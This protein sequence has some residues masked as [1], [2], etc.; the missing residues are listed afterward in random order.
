MIEVEQ[1]LLK[2]GGDVSPQLVEKLTAIR[3]V[4]FWYIR[5]GQT[6]WNLENR[7]MGSTDISLNTNGERQ[8]L[9]ARNHFVGEKITTICHSPLSRAKKTA[10][11]LNKTLNC[12]LI[13]IEELK[14]CN[15]GPYE[16]QIF[17]KWFQDWKAGMELQATE[18]YTNFIS[19]ALVGINKALYLPGPVLIVAHGGVYW[20]IEQTLQVCIEGGL[21]NCIPVFHEP[22]NNK[23]AKWQVYKKTPLQNIL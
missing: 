5:H 23:Y 3:E 21:H 6:D 10:E 11:I 17:G 13:E 2:E 7:L 12:N 15:L 16:G 19:R 20:A 4:S 8:A 9:L 1:Q 18:S 22:P 14:E